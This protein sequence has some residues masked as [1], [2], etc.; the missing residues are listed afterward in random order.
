MPDKAKHIK[1][2]ATTQLYQAPATELN[3]F[4]SVQ[5]I[6]NNKTWYHF[7]GRIGRLRY[8]AYMMW[9]MILAFLVIFLVGFILNLAENYDLVTSHA[10]SDSDIFSVFIAMLVILIGSLLAIYCLILLPKRRLHDLGH[11]AWFALLMFI[12]F[13]NVIL[14]LYLM[15]AKGNNGVNQYGMPARPN[16]IIHYIFGLLLPLLM[17][18]SMLGVKFVIEY[19]RYKAERMFEKLNIPNFD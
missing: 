7:S 18:A 12:P 19:E 17:V 10:L 6:P 9:A 5:V 11:S 2:S 14:M 15:F 1:S 13:I 4:L 8:I 16:K 3:Q